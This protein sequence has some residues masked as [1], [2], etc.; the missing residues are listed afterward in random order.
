VSYDERRVQLDQA[1]LD[2]AA[3]KM[4]RR[5]IL[6]VRITPGAESW[7][8]VASSGCEPYGH[9]H[10]GYRSASGIC[11]SRWGTA[12]YQVNVKVSAF[13]TQSTSALDN[14]AKIN[15]K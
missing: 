1:T 11:D 13:R 7:C 3:P 4:G 5:I 15:T 6:R 12:I 8:C 2:E 9:L 10:L 14:F